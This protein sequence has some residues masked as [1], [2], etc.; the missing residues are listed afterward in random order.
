MYFKIVILF[1]LLLSLTSCGP[2]ITLSPKLGSSKAN[3]TIAFAPINKS[4]DIRDE[5][6]EL[7]RNSIVA[8]LKSKGY[9][10]LEKSIVN[11]ICEDAKCI[12]KNKLFEQYNVGALLSISLETS[13]ETDW[14]IISYN[15]INGNAKLEDSAG[16]DLYTASSSASKS[17]GLILQSGQIIKA[18]KNIYINSAD[19]TFLNLSSTLANDLIEPLPAQDSSILDEFS[20]VI[21][22]VNKSKINSDFYKVCIQGT[23]NSLASIIY[24]KERTTLRE[25]S[26]G[27]YCGSVYGSGSGETLN[28]ELRS[29]YG[30]QALS[31]IGL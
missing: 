16:R 28:L 15:A 11:E 23:P 6:A 3:L 26:M 12:N 29:P 7:F 13:S 20:S 31:K 5:R 9:F 2:T 22:N 19:E 14:G 21:E 8:K 10:L 17:G 25:I 4:S 24:N 18:I 1:I 27:R 30:V